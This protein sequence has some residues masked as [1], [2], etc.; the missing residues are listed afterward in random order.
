MPR[1]VKERII[2]IAIICGVLGFGTGIAAIAVAFVTSGVA[3]VIAIF[4]STFIISSCILFGIDL[5]IKTIKEFSGKGKK[6]KKE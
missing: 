3:I 1:D 6:T 5:I 2:E 4:A